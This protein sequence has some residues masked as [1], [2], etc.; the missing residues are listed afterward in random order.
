MVIG[1]V[2]R[3]RVSEDCS[4]RHCTV[5]YYIKTNDSVFKVCQKTLCD[6]YKITPRRVQ[7]LV[8]KI[9]FN[10]PMNDG[11]GTHENR[12]N[13]IPDENKDLV[14]SHVA[15]FPLQE[16]HYSRNES[17][18]QCLSPDLGIEKMWNLFKEKYPYT[19][20]TLHYYRDIFNTKFNLRFGVPRSDTCDL[21]D[22]L[23][24]KMKS[25]DDPHKLRELQIES[26]L[27]H[28]RA[29]SAYTSLGNDKKTGEINKDTICL[30]V[31]LEQVLYCPTLTHGNV[32]YQRQLSC[33]NLC[34][35]DEGNNTAMMFLWDETKGKRGSSEIAS[36]ILAFVTHNFTPLTNNKTRHLIIWSDRCTGQNN[37]WKMVALMQHLVI[38]NYFITVDQKFMTTGHSFLPCDRDFALIERQKKHSMVYVPSQWVEVIT[39]SSDKFSVYV[40]SSEDFKDLSIVEKSLRT[41]TFRITHYVWLRI[42]H[43]DPCTLQARVSHNILLPWTSHCVAKKAKGRRHVNLPP[44]KVSR[45]PRLYEG[46][47]SIKKEKKADLMA[48]MPYV[49][50]E[51]REF[52]T[53]INADD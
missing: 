18:K 32:F 37:N 28:A 35:H 13:K 3:R 14:M 48:M 30:C 4:T 23:F 16:N 47:L 51:F 46:P 9:K 21:C 12:P 53:N 50:A 24:I 44:V 7:I 33:Y 31:D 42:T 5:Q 8:D 45:F 38:N 43:D 2:K 11:R 41:G 40:M 15:S 10:K 52:Y 34:V 36:C 6:I 49:P 17:K 25:T 39:A 22:S 20:V 19:Q 29:D 26:Q 27:H 1:E